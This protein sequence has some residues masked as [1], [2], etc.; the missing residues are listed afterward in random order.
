MAQIST[1]TDTDERLQNAATSGGP[2]GFLKLKRGAG[3][4]PAVPAAP[5]R[6]RERERE[7]THTQ[8]TGGYTQ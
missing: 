7:S 4:A 5:E 8:P 6:E 2:A 3:A 1:V